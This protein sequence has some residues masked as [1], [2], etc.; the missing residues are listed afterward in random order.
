MGPLEGIK[1]L[2]LGQLVAGPFAARL[3]GEFGAEVI[4]VEPPQSGDPLRSWRKLHDGTSLWWRVQA[5]NKQSIAIDMRQ[6]EGQELV[7]KLAAQADIVVENFRPGTLERWGLGYD[8]L[9]ESNP[10]LIM[11]RMSGFGQTGP[12]ATMPGFGAV[13]ESMGGMRYVNG[14]IDQMPARLNLSIGDSLMGLHGVIGAMMA[15][16]ERSRSGKGQI[17][18]AA[19]YESVFNV[20][21]SILPEYS[22]DGTVRQRLGASLSGIVPSNTYQSSDKEYIVIAGNGDSIFKRLM[23]GIGRPDLADDP[24]LAHNSGRCERQVELDE[25]IGS[26]CKAHSKEE[27]IRTMQACEVPHGKIFSAA[28]IFHDPQYRAREMI[29]ERKLA[30]GRCIA[31]PGIVPKLSRTPGQVTNLGPELGEQTAAILQ[32]LGVNDVDISAL[33]E[34]GV[35]EL[36]CPEIDATRPSDSR[37]T[38][39]R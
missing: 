9:S 33:Q 21:E 22:Y 15:L 3:L 6:A 14:F 32:R 11:V 26:W 23:R 35:I 16:H 4:K 7:R 25:V 17:V 10:G 12:M 13:G 24:Q 8:R 34:R 18:D 38:R 20:M 2:E 37:R 1:V 29:L 36:P 31:V 27:I 28:D 5:R 19:L 39:A 30:D